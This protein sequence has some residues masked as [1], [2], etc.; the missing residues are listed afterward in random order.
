MTFTDDAALHLLLR[1][2]DAWKENLP[3][4]L[5]YRGI[6]SSR[7]A[8]MFLSLINA[9][10]KIMPH[11]PAAPALFVCGDDVLARVHADIILLSDTPKIQIDH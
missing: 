7:N 10:K 5:K 3:E 2:M 11:R 1:D 4:D 8:G 6:E 9:R